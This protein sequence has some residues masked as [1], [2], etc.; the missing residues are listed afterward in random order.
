MTGNQGGKPSGIPKEQW[1]AHFYKPREGSLLFG[2][3]LKEN[4]FTAQV[5][6]TRGSRYTVV[7]P[8]RLV[9]F[10]LGSE[11]VCLAELTSFFHAAFD[12]RKMGGFQNVLCKKSTPYIRGLLTAEA[13]TLV[14]FFPQLQRMSISG[15][16][17]MSKLTNQ[18]QGKFGSGMIGGGEWG[19]KEEGNRSNSFAYPPVNIPIQLVDAQTH[20]A[21]DDH[22]MNVDVDHILPPSLIKD[23]I[24]GGLRYPIVFRG[25]IFDWEMLDWS[26]QA[27]VEHLG[28]MKLPFRRGQKKVTESPQWERGCSTEQLTMAEFFQEDTSDSWLYFDYKYMHEWFQDHPNILQA[29]TWANLG[30]PERTGS[31]STMWIGSSGAHTPCHIDTYGCNIVAQVMGRKQWILFPPS[32]PAMLPTRVPYEESSIYSNRNFYSPGPDMA[33]VEKRG[34]GSAQFLDDSHLIGQLFKLRAGQSAVS[35]QNNL[36]AHIGPRIQT[37]TC[38]YLLDEA[39]LEASFKPWTISLIQVGPRSVRSVDAMLQTSQM[40]AE[41]VSQNS[42]F[43]FMFVTTSHEG[44]AQFLDDSHL[45]GQLFKLRAG[46]SAVSHQNNLSAHIGP[47]IQTVTCS[48]LL[49]EACLEA[50]FKPWTISLI[51]VGPRSV[52]SVDAMLQTSQMGAELH[53]STSFRFFPVASKDIRVRSCSSLD[54]SANIYV[55]ISPNIHGQTAAESH[56]CFDF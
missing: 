48:Y 55:N 36:S 10:S 6:P 37:V 3:L 49:D 39:C 43:S 50:S 54:T 51:Q 20:H 38:S 13:D 25:L 2:N 24:L 1:L 56:V 8:Y 27:W 34:E 52:R 46:Q 21:E 41:L 5:Q 23:M 9:S 30:F 33:E 42:L 29:V 31:E 16:P 53:R 44:S 35:H 22:K 40:G 15:V 17:N 11:K 12:H 19:F 7:Q 4:I 32:A 28:D 14:I 26:P 18:V 47:R 45:I